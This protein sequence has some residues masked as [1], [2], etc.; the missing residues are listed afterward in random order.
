MVL[1]ELMSTRVLT[2]NSFE[3]AA[4]A[5]TRMRSEM[6]RHAIVLRDGKVVGVLSAGDLGNAR[7][8]SARAGYVVG[9]L[10]SREPVTATPE[11]DVRAAAHTMRAHAVGCLPVMEGEK[12]AGI[13]TVFD[14]LGV[15]E[16]EPTPRD[17]EA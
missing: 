10:M 16:S 14:L 13:V 15:L 4:D 8:G 2:L 5:L 3:R 11:M 12:I 9:E 17:D 1:R 7:A 6:V